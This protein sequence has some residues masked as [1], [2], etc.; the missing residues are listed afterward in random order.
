MKT[1]IPAPGEGRRVG[2]FVSDNDQG[3]VASVSAPSSRGPSSRNTSAGAAGFI[4][5]TMVNTTSEARRRIMR[6]IKSRDTGPELIVRSIAHRMGYRF[7]VC[8][9][10]LPGC[11]DIVFSG[12]RKVIL[13]HG[14]FWHGHDCGG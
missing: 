8:R 1:G 7:R 3:R 4:K 9:R 11:P 5:M 14:C 2:H 12:L 6:A 13:V 10:D